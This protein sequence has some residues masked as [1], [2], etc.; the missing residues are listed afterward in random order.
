MTSVDD[1]RRKQAV[2]I[3]EVA[4]LSVSVH[5]EL[6]KHPAQSEIDASRACSNAYVADA[7]VLVDKREHR[8]HGRAH[9]ENHAAEHE[10]IGEAH[11]CCES[12]SE[13]R[14][15]VRKS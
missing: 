8:V 1:S 11:V 5:A 12:E 2:V 15:K 14:E 3:S 6:E 7:F 10:L 9:Y 4:R 13:G